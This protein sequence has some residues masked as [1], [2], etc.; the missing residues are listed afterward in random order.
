MPVL[1]G[2]T[3]PVAAENVV[4]LLWTTPNLVALFDTRDRLI[5]AFDS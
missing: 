2:S 3:L 4:E 5:L 1:T